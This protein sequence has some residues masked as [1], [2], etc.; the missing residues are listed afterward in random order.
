M[1][2]IESI[3]ASSLALAAESI[4]NNVMDETDG[5][6]DITVDTSEVVA[7]AEVMEG[8]AEEAQSSIKDFIAFIKTFE[9]D[10]FDSIY[11]EREWRSVKDFNFTFDDVAMIVA[12]KSFNGEN[13]FQTLVKDAKSLKIPRQIPIVPWEDLIEN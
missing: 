3:D 10:E 6:Y 5:Y 12:P 11:C 2:S 4:E 13:Y 8:Y 1:S 7:E 9:E